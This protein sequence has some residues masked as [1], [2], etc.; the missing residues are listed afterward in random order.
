QARYADLLEWQLYNAASV[1]MGL[2]GTS[3][4]YNNPLTCRGG[5]TRRAWYQVPCCP[6]NLSRTW[7]SLGKYLYSLDTEGF[8][9]HQYVGSE[10][11]VDLGLPMRVRLESGLPWQGSVALH[12]SPPS[13]IEFTLHL[14]IPSWAQEVQL[15]INGHRLH[16]VQPPQPPPPSGDASTA[17]PPAS[18]YSP[19]QAYY[20]PLSRTWMPG[21]VVEVE[22]PLAITI[23]RPH[24]RVRSVQGRVALTRGPLVYC[25]ESVD[26]PGLDI[27]EAQINP[28]TLQ[29][30]FSPD[31]LG[32]VWLLQGETIQGEPFTAIPYFC[33]ANRGESEMTVWV[34]A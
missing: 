16:P 11:E 7:A 27:F 6:S 33:W 12:L 4:L 25:L 15:R 28:S 34:R 1:G 3:Y 20:V 5:V 13:P 23:R 10:V 22:F 30:E 32:G 29:A 17:E 18:G 19:H 26:N 2:D 21:D 14:R 8:W 31:H 9:V 24:R